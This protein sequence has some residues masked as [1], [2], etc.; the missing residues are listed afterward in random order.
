MNRAIKTYILPATNHIC[1]RIKAVLYCADSEKTEA[2]ITIP[3]DD[4][5][6]FEGNHIAARNWLIEKINNQSF[7]GAYMMGQLQ[8]HVVHIKV[9]S[10]SNLEYLGRLKK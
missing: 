9:Y 10:N 7:R 4:N 1:K 6:T 3:Y 5:I 2:S 8:S